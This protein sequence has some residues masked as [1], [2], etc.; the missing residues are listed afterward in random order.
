MFHPL[1]WEWVLHNCLLKDCSYVYARAVCSRNGWDAGLITPYA[2]VRGLGES[3]FHNVR[4][5]VGLRMGM[6]ETNTHYIFRKRRLMYQQKARLLRLLFLQ[7]LH[8]LISMQFW[9][10]V[11]L[12]MLLII[13]V[14]LTMK[15]FS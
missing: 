4:C 13:C 8:I 9:Q 6:D 10:F 7:L 5:G 15:V 2:L 3:P 11:V 1:D 12:Q 14:L